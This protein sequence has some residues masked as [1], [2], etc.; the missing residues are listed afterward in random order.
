[1]LPAARCVLLLVVAACNRQPA[2]TGDGAPGQVEPAPVASETDGATV[3]APSV[4]AAAADARDAGPAAALAPDDGLA[5]VEALRPGP[6]EAD[7]ALLLRLRRH[8]GAVLKIEALVRSGDAWLVAYTWDE[9]DAWWREVHREGKV[10][11]V[12][13]D[14]RQRRLAC[15][16]ALRHPDEDA[17]GTAGDATGDVAIDDFDPDAENAMD[18]R[19]CWERALASL[20]PREG[21]I[22]GDCHALSVAR[23]TDAAVEDLWSHTGSCVE[24]PAAFELVDVAGAGWPQLALQVRA[25]HWDMT[26]MG[27]QRAD[28]TARLVVLD[29]RKA[30]DAVMLEQVVA[31]ETHVDESWH[32][33]GSY[34]H[35][36]FKR[37]GH[38]TVLEQ[39]WRTSDACEVDGAGWAVA[40]AGGD[41]E[42]FEPCTVE[43]T[44]TRT[45]WD[46]ARQRW[47]GKA[48]ALP[49]PKRLPD[50]D[51][52]LPVSLPGAGR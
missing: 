17:T 2:P 5:K 9:V 21:P 12:R 39:E 34:A 26:R 28:T 23:I 40:D 29:P 42:T 30:D 7:R 19:S 37:G 38:V 25:V 44:V 43:W 36:T 49:R 1:M 22:E 31:Y 15:E 41:D 6:D 13:A 51:R 3:A 48:E 35:V 14:L 20:A 18:E 16:A 10:A 47:S 11:E 50:R 45:P 27:F 24:T 8:T 32:W 4:A 33:E 52:E 46:P